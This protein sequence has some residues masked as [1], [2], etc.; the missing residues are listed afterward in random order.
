MSKQLPSTKWI[1]F[2]PYCCLHKS[3]DH[4]RKLYKSSE[5]FCSQLNVALSYFL[6]VR[7]TNE[8]IVLKHRVNEQ[9]DGQRWTDVT[10]LT[11]TD[12]F[13]SSRRDALGFFPKKLH[14]ED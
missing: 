2:G 10:G 1:S 3:N 9:A 4:W 8:E 13:V 12:L 14:E 11:V 5:V 6:K 7:L